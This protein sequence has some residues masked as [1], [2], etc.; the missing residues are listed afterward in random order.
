MTPARKKLWEHDDYQ[1][2]ILG[3]CLSMA[4]LR[5]L[6]RKL[7]LSLAPGASDY[8]VHVQFVRLARREGPVAQYLNK[9]LDR[10]YRK[11]AFYF[12]KANWNPDEPFVYIA[13]RRW[14]RRVKR[15]QTLKVYSNAPEV[16]MLL[17]GV[18]LGKRSGV[19]GVF[20]WENVT[21]AEGMNDLEARSDSG[22]D[23]TR[24]EIAEDKIHH[25]IN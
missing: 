8:D 4:E 13:E 15:T 3:T 10:K 9:Y 22:I 11:D 12:Y 6:A 18:S 16:E 2:P 20:T 19:N 7:D 25:G 21:M 14:D 24:I 5:K 1:C 23:H 17:N